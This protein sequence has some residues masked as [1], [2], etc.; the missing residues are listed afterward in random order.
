MMIMEFQISPR[1]RRAETLHR[2]LDR[3]SRWRPEYRR[4][5]SRGTRY[6]PSLPLTAPSSWSAFK[7]LPVLRNVCNCLFVNYRIIYRRTCES[8]LSSKSWKLSAKRAGGKTTESATRLLRFGEI[9]MFPNHTVSRN[10]CARRDTYSKWHN[11][12]Y[13]YII[14]NKITL[15]NIVMYSIV[16]WT[17]IEVSLSLNENISIAWSLKS[18]AMRML[19]LHNTWVIELETNFSAP[20]LCASSSGVRPPSSRTLR[21]SCNADSSSLERA[22]CSNKPVRHNTKRF[23][24]E[25]PNSFLSIQIHVLCTVQCEYTL[26]ACL[27]CTCVTRISAHR[28]R[29]L[30]AHLRLSRNLLVLLCCQKEFY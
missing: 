15:V 4:S 16:F 18:K 7:I 14:F 3:A 2:R 11:Y 13:S 17:I 5:Y 1:R 9:A 24:C 12:P 22:L 29:D 6:L 23:Q 21:T 20:A 8:S 19:L 26:V 10:P 30:R 25:C 28:L 27:F